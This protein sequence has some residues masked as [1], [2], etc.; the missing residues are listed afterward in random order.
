MAATTPRFDR[1]VPAAPDT[2]G[3]LR[4]E[5]RRWARRQGASPAIQANVA[6]AFSEA[7]TSLIG[8]AP[9]AGGVPGPLMI[10]AWADGDELGVR[11]SHRSRGVPS[12]PVGVGYGFGLALMARVCDRFEVRRRE[13]RPGTAVL[14]RFS[15]EREPSPARSSPRPPSRST[16]RR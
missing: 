16:T 1:M 5:L 6:L 2:I 10:Q 14:M 11:V 15:L 8:P 4:R 3:A 12:P 9:A 13:D 7:C